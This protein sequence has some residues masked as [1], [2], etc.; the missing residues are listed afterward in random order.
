MKIDQAVI[1]KFTFPY[2]G[3]E[4]MIPIAAE[5]QDQ[6]MDKL[7]GFMVSWVNELMPKSTL[8][9]VQLSKEKV[10]IPIVDPIML[11]MRIEELVQKLIPVKKPKG[12]ASIERLVKEWTGFPMEPQNYASIIAELSR[13]NPN[14]N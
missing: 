9:P 1:Y 11:A 7:R 13:M 12:A 3:T 5:S 2:E 14:G 6:A 4:L 10:D 8:S